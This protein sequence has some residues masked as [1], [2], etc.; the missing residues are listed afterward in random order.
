MKAYF[1]GRDI[2][3]LRLKGA[4][5][6]KVNP[7]KM[8]A[9][10][11]ARKPLGEFFSLIVFFSILFCFLSREFGKPRAPEPCIFAEIL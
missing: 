1:P 10:I 4:R 2:R 8:T 3:S 6:N 9:A 5:E 7:E 11:M